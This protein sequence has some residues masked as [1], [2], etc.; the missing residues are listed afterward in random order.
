MA[1]FLSVFNL[2]NQINR[3]VTFEE[4]FGTFE[5]LFTRRTDKGSEVWD[6]VAFKNG[7]SGK[8]TG[9]KTKDKAFDLAVKQWGER[10]QKSDHQRSKSTKT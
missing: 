6:C 8:A 1:A 4:K 5:C 10:L 7:H 9:A 3:D 2:Q